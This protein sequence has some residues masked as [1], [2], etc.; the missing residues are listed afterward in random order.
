MRRLHWLVVATSLALGPITALAEEDEG[1]LAAE[2]ALPSAGTHWLAEKPVGT[3][4]GPV[5]AE[6]L[7]AGPSDPSR[8]LLYGGDYRN[9]RH[10]PLKTLSPATAGKLQVAWAPHR[11]A[12][13]PVSP[14]VRRRD[15]RDPSYNRLFA[16]DA[17]TARC[18][19]ATTIRSEESAPV[20]RS[21]ELAWASPATPC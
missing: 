12:R 5:S 3:S 9:F 17:K 8:W 11:H 6:M 15:V 19:G 10:S 1:E 18:C 21:A 13:S 20:L 14:V 7:A 4:V 2:I 16:L